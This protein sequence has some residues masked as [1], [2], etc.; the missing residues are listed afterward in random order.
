M[1]L[2]SHVHEYLISGLLY[3][4]SILLALLLDTHVVVLRAGPLVGTYSASVYWFHTF[5]IVSFFSSFYC[6]LYN[7]L[8]LNYLSFP[9]YTTNNVTF[10]MC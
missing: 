2:R 4:F 7:L 3:A 1:R 5:P 8:L 10:S 9:S 6:N